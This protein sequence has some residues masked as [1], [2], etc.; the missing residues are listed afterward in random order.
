[1]GKVVGCGAW[2]WMGF[3]VGGVE[4]VRR[5]QVGLRIGRYQLFCF[6]RKRK[7][8]VSTRAWRNFG[9]ERG[10]FKTQTNTNDHL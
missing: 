10:T 7:A 3:W 9:G 6:V 8:D 2:G 4:A 5:L 1:M